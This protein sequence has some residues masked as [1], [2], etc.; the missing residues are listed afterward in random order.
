MFY[1]L[2]WF[3]TQ[4]LICHIKGCDL[5]YAYE[6]QYL[7][8]VWCNRCNNYHSYVSMGKP[9]KNLFINLKEEENEDL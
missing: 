7:L 8:E 2:K 9:D 5:E 3:L 4:R 1:L 6:Q